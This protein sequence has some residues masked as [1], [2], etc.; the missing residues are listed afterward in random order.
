MKTLNQYFDE[1]MQNEEFRKEYEEIQPEMDIIRALVDARTSE[2]MSQK[3]LSERTG[4]NQAD[5]SKIENG[6]RNPSLS[7]LKRL[8]DGLGMTLR[9]EFTPKVQ[10]KQL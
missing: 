5:I 10:T 9:L 6:T 3:E 7:M 2:G 4:I 1:Q 8:A